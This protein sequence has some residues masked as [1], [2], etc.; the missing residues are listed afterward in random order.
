LRNIIGSD[1]DHDSGT[2]IGAGFKIDEDDRIT[3]RR[4]PE[5]GTATIDETIFKETDR[6]WK[7][8]AGERKAIR[9]PI[10]IGIIDNQ[11]SHPIGI[12]GFIDGEIL[13]KVPEIGIDKSIKKEVLVLIGTGLDSKGREV[14]IQV[15]IGVIGILNIMPR[16]IAKD[17]GSILSLCGNRPFRII[18]I[19]FGKDKRSGRFGEIERSKDEI[20]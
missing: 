2:V 17:N 5:F 18:I 20:L 7:A 15:I 10:G 19:K 14:Y 13:R 4:N 16:I 12:E 1:I 8:T 6:G 11:L 3:G 9:R